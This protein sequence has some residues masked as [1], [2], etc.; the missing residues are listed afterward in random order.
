MKKI[1][2]SSES[3]EVELMEDLMEKEGIA[4]TVQT[5][6]GAIPFTECFP[7]LWV[8]NDEDAPKAQALLE[9]RLKPKE[10]AGSTWT[11]SECG[12]QIDEQFNSCWKCGTS[13]IQAA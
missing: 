6:T 1:F 7:E 13:R 4:C 11:C 10:P 12:E 2:T 8:L 5:S 9:S 3:A